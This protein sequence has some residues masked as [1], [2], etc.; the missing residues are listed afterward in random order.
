MLGIGPESYYFFQGLY[1]TGR[2]VK[3]KIEEQIMIYGNKG[4]EEDSS[5]PDGEELEI[6]SISRLTGRNR[7]GGYK[8]CF[9]EY[10]LQVHEDTLIKYR[11]LK[12]GIFTKTELEDIV[13]ADEKQKAYAAALVQ[14]SRKPR[15]RYELFM[16]L[17]EKGWGEERIEQTLNRL[18]S[19]GLVNDAVY[20][21]D[22]AAYRASQQG[23]GKVWIRQE[24]RQKG[25][26]KL[27]IEAALGAVDEET[28][29]AGA[30]KLAEKRWRITDETDGSLV[31][32]QKRKIAAFLLRRGYSGSVAS[33]VIKELAEG[34][35]SDNED[36]Y[37][38]DIW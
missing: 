14:L 15:T 26:A 31:R 36:E 3:V 2:F 4:Q 34:V 13:Q 7:A 1:E 11:M 25:V 32:E 24:L 22:W 30:R 29:L 27:H 33:R 20:A 18:E 37:S 19:E 6:T 35:L 28:E 38:G 23:K 9:G 5:L 12:G 21:R 16:K 8:V 17:K 10:A